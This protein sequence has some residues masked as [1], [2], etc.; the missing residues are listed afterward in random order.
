MKYAVNTEYNNNRRRKYLTY[1]AECLRG[2][3]LERKANTLMI[4]K[5]YKE[6]IRFYIKALKSFIKELNE[7]LYFT[8]HYYCG[9]YDDG[10]SLY[11][12]IKI[13]KIYRNIRK[14]RRILNNI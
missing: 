5:K 2:K 6:A 4:R 7:R 10:H 9:I 14:A 12:N 11:M 8:N 3:I 1:K 13:K